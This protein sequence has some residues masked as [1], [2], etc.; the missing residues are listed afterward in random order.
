MSMRRMNLPEGI[1]R[2]RGIRISCKVLSN[3]NHDNIHF[4]NNLQ[5]DCQLKI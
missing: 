1:W 4:Y 2:E 3:Q 5:I